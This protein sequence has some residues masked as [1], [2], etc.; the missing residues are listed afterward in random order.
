[1]RLRGMMETRAG[2]GNAADERRRKR[3]RGTKEWRERASERGKSPGRRETCRGRNEFEKG[4]SAL[5]RSYL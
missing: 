2:D 5:F 3:G 1:M 4:L